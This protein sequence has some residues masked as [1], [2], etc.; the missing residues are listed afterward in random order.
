MLKGN[1]CMVSIEQNRVWSRECAKFVQNSDL[2]FKCWLSILIDCPFNYCL[3]WAPTSDREL[4]SP[5]P[6]AATHVHLWIEFFSYFIYIYS[7]F[8]CLRFCSL[9][10]SN[11]H[12]IYWKRS[13]QDQCKIY[14]T[15]LKTCKFD[16]LTLLW[17]FISKAFIRFTIKK[18]IVNHFLVAM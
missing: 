9:A 11:S 1:W 2:V 14:L 4:I 5:C 7:Y 12:M 17:C 18:I 3:G 16:Y 15:F 10:V 13:S 8:I 6:F